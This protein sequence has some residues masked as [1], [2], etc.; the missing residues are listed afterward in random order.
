VNSVFLNH[1]HSN[2][3]GMKTQD[4]QAVGVMFIGFAV[5]LG[6]LGELGGENAF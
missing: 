6:V 3:L 4:Y 1:K 2:W 5:T